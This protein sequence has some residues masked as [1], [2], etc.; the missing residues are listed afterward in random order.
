MPQGKTMK[1]GFKE[2]LKAISGGCAET[3]YIAENSSED[4]LSRL[5]EALSGAECEVIYM[6]STKELG[7]YCKIDVGASCAAVM[8]D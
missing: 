3:V 8:K 6:Q 5:R 4:M 7:A 1:I 2:V